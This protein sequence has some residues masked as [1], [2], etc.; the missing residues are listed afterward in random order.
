[1]VCDRPPRLR[2]SKVALQHFIDGAATPPFQG[3]EYMSPI[4]SPIGRAATACYR[5]HRCSA[6][7]PRDLAFSPRLLRVLWT[8]GVTAG[9]ISGFSIRQGRAEQIKI[10]ASARTEFAA[11]AWRSL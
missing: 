1:M 6:R 9:L 8:D 3:G 2:L 7:V 10:A 5:F 4:H 11:R